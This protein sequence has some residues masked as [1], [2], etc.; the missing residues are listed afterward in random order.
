M[1]KII[2]HPGHVLGK[3]PEGGLR[4]S[5]PIKRALFACSCIFLYDDG[6]PATQS[7]GRQNRTHKT[8]KKNKNSYGASHL[9]GHVKLGYNFKQ[10]GAGCG[11]LFK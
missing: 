4:F 6:F 2:T 10:V 9:R 11:V 7:R 5:G 3:F 8:P 1:G